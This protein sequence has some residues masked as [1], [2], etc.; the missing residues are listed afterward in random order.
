MGGI[1][2]KV[3]KSLNFLCNLTKITEF[4]KAES[5]ENEAFTAIEEKDVFPD[6]LWVLRDFSLQNIS[7]N[8]E[9]Y[10]L[11]P[12]D[13]LERILKN[14]DLDNSLNVSEIY[15]TDSLSSTNKIYDNI[16]KYFPKRE[17]FTLISPL[18]QE[19]TGW[20]DKSYKVKQ[21]PDFQTLPDEKISPE[22]LSQVLSLRKKI[23]NN[24]KKKTFNGIKLNSENFL[25]II[26]DYISI[27]NK[28][29]LPILS[30]I[31][32]NICESENNKAFQEAENIYIESF[33]KNLSKKPLDENE[34]NILHDKAKKKSMQIFTRNSIGAISEVLKKNL[35]KKIDNKKI[36]GSPLDFYFIF[37]LVF[38]IN[39]SLYLLI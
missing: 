8:N 10:K 34:L 20:L 1:N 25:R 24:C 7:E 22:F 30:S 5:K 14:T 27:F 13:Y 36:E 39:V 38:K 9:D 16:K 23:I 19:V 12:N 18:L 28:G 17:C 4:E 26:K 11:N 33:R 31:Y 32:N 2:E 3:L 37:K 29:K 15:G 21:I 6:L 35:K